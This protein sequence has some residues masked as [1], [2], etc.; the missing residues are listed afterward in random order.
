MVS[1]PARGGSDKIPV[2]EFGLKL[3]PGALAFLLRKVGF[4]DAMSSQKR[5]TLNQ[6]P[7]PKWHP[8]GCSVKGR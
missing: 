7:T 6:P 3:M 8:S 4:G 2:R 1:Q 5:P